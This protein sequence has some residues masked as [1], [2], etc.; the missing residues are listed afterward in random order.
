LLSVPVG[1]PKVVLDGG[2]VQVSAKLVVL[3]QPCKTTRFERDPG[4]DSFQART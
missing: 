1:S 4:S 2:R 3:R